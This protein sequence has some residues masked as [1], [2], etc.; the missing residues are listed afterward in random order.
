[1]KKAAIVII[2]GGL[3]LSLAFISCK[4]DKDTTPNN[5]VTTQS[6]N[7]TTSLSG[8]GS[9][10]GQPSGTP[11]HLPSNIKV[12]GSMVGGYPGSKTHFNYP[13]SLENIQQYLASVPKSE[14]TE[15]GYGTYIDVYMKLRNTSNSAYSLIIPAGL[16]M[17]DS[18]PEDSTVT[19]TSQSGII[20]VPD[21]I[22]IP[23]GDTVGIC[24]KSFCLNLHHSI[25]S[26][27][28]VYLL[29]VITNNDQLHSVVTILQNK[30]SIAE[31]IYEIQG[32]LWE[33][34]DGDGLTQED[35]DLMN[36][37]H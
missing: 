35:I 7:L 19:D 23:G 11:Y 25:P 3:V 34:T 24:L 22:V 32:I 8:L 17:C 2:L 26:S 15:Y 33:I 18:I 4:K 13:K 10:G 28:N 36:S 21:T 9:H 6:V 12:I 5:N 29:K 14:Y 37:W 30:K 1:M 20:I 27:H 31:H 16:I